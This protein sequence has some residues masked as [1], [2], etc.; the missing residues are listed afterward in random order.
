MFVS[1]L[2]CAPHPA[3]HL[4]QEQL[5]MRKRISRIDLSNDDFFSSIYF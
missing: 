4:Q 1:I 5:V 3:A 2:H